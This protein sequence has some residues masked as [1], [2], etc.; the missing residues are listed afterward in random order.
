MGP[1]R[2]KS[3]EKFVKLLSQRGSTVHVGPSLQTFFERDCIAS[4]WLSFRCIGIL[5]VCQALINCSTTE[6]LLELF[7][8]K[9]Q[10]LLDHFPLRINRV[11]N[12][13]HDVVKKDI[14]LVASNDIKPIIGFVVILGSLF[15]KLLPRAQHH[16][17]FEFVE[18]SCLNRNAF[19]FGEI[20][21]ELSIAAKRW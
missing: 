9:R 12:G 8:L 18:L 19:L 13:N 2:G 4:A 17:R 5:I 11:V 20:H 14:D 15:H 6:F 3:T 7:S 10:P 21:C 1:L 16:N